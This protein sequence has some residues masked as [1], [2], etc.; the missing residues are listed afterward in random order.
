[1]LS[2]HNS[3]FCDYLQMVGQTRTLQ[4]GLP[5]GLYEIL[6]NFK[7]YFGLVIIDCPGSLTT[8]NGMKGLMETDVVV[9]N[10]R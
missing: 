5:L 2:N 7:K 6:E 9:F 1:M 4:I 3:E 8:N 10:H